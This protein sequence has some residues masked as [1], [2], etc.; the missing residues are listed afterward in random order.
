MQKE[1]RDCAGLEMSSVD[2]KDV[3]LPTPKPVSSRTAA[4]CFL[5]VAQNESGG[6][7]KSEDC[8]GARIAAEPAGRF[9]ISGD[10]I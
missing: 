9:I 6:I 3:N 2:L 10:V 5:Q 4:F 8:D 1:T 7:Q